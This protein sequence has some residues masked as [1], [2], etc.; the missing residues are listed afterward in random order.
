LIVSIRRV[1]AI[2]GLLLICVGIFGQEPPKNPTGGASQS[3]AAHEKQPTHCDLK[4]IVQCFKDVAHDQAG[5]WTSPLR[6]KS[7]DALWLVPF[8]GATGAAFAYDQDALRQVGTTNQTLIDR[9]AIIS[10]FGSPY[11]TFGEAGVFYLTGVLTHNDHLRETGVLGAEA[12]VDAS[13]VSGALKLVSNRERPDHGD[14]T[15]GF[16][17]RGPS[18]YTLDGSFP[19]GHAASS[20]ALAR[21]ISAEYPGW[22]TRLCAYGFATTISASRI[23]ARQHF[24]SDVVVGSVFGYLIGGYVI[25]HHSSTAQSETDYS[26]MPIIDDSRHTYGLTVMFTP[27]SKDLTRMGGSFRKIGSLFGTGM[28]G[29]L[30]LKRQD[31]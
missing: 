25:R 19:S 6:L 28:V 24:P 27:S 12:V 17:P 10:Q 18:D 20:W 21:V 22:L 4:T 7:H 23:T 13:I 15:G 29:T 8:A 5:I 9:S 2:A 1:S 16:W 14:G 26:V 11:A 3:S 31:F 30:A